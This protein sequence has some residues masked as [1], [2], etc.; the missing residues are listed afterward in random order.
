[1][2]TK[3]QHFIHLFSRLI[4]SLYSCEVSELNERQELSPLSFEA[5]L[6]Y[7]FGG[8]VGEKEVGENCNV[9]LLSVYSSIFLKNGSRTGVAS[10]IESSLHAGTTFRV[11]RLIIYK[12]LLL[13][14]T[15]IY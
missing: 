4:L 2:A 14:L 12:A 8:P 5:L 9:F 7:P 15:Y 3:G 11:E 13:S 1:M 6:S 10:Y